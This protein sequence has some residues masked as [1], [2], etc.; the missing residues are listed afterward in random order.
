M[1]EKQCSTQLC[2]QL[3]NTD[4]M[5]CL[6]KQ[7][8]V[9]KTT[10]TT[11]RTVEDVVSTEVSRKLRVGLNCG[12]TSACTHARTSVCKCDICSSMNLL[13]RIL[14]NASSGVGPLSCAYASVLLGRTFARSESRLTAQLLLGITPYIDVTNQY[15]NRNSKIE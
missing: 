7:Q 9:E 15:S 8:K 14:I 4:K 5:C 12:S 6:C 3:V 2:T 10:T 11:T 13:W 1:H